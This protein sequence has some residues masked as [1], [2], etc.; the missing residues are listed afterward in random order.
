LDFKN[1]W[2][3]KMPNHQASYRVIK[4]YSIEEV[5]QTV[6]QMV[7]N[8]LKPIGGLQAIKAYHEK[9]EDNKKFPILFFQTLFKE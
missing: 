9:E 2:K 8:G 3:I 7:T 6:A 4:G 1:K 5:Q